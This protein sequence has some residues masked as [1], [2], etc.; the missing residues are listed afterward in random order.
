MDVGGSDRSLQEPCRIIV[1]ECPLSQC[2]SSAE[3]Y[4]AGIYEYVLPKTL[5][6]VCGSWGFQN[7]V[8]VITYSSVTYMYRWT[9]VSVGN[10]FQ[11]LPR[12]Q[13][14]AD[15]TERYI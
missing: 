3:G 1:Q 4:I 10:M 14:T 6:K 9:A 8:F 2:H 13:K 7:Y 11:G 5:V 15:T 12:L